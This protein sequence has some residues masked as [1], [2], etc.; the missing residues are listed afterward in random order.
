MG[1]CSVAKDI[2]MAA[3][4]FFLSFIALIPAAFASVD[5]ETATLAA[6][7]GSNPQI[8]LTL[9]VVNKKADLVAKTIESLGQSDIMDHNP[10]LFIWMA[11]QISDAGVAVKEWA[12]RNPSVHVQWRFPTDKNQYG[13]VK[14]HIELMN[15]LQRA[16][17]NFDYVV[18]ITDKM[19]FPRKWFD[20]LWR[21]D[22]QLIN[23][24]QTACGILMPMVHN[25][26]NPLKMTVPQL[27]KEVQQWQSK[28][29]VEINPLWVLP[30]VFKKS[31]LEKV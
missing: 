1:E 22:V 21:T 31:L 3:S 27:E 30:W 10:T 20:Q 7:A 13:L 24:D 29:Q 19:L 15:E 2:R 23:A 12:A 14:P 17:W 18:E 4:C 9:V 8:A 11:D 26:Y 6:E 16:Y 28:K 5:V 25:T